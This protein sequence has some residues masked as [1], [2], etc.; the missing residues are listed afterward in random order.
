MKRGI[1]MN[2]SKSKERE[3]K[4]KSLL[5]F[6]DNYVV[7]DIET[8][9]LSPEYDSIIELCAQKYINRKLDSVYSSLINPGFSID[10]FITSLTGIT[11]EMLSDAPK[12]GE[13]II[14]F[15]NFIG[16]NILVGHNVN[17]DINFVYDSFEFYLHKPLKN[18]FVDTLRFARRLHKDWSHN[19]LQD[20]SKR[21]SFPYDGAH[22]ANFDC[23]L[24]NSILEKFRKEF[25]EQYGVDA[26]PSIA[27]S[28]YL[29]GKNLKASDIVT[30]KTE[31]DIDNPIYA[32]N[33]V[34]TGS[35]EKMTR[36]EAMQ[37]IADYGGINGD[38]V[39]KKTDYLI[40]GNNDYCSS[41]KNGKSAKHKKAEQLKL[42]GQNIEILPENVFYDMLDLSQFKSTGSSMAAVR[43]S[44]SPLMTID[45][46]EQIEIDIFQHI[47]K[48]LSTSGQDISLLR[49]YLDS[50]K[51]MHISN[52][53]G[54]IRFKMRGKKTYF[55]FPNSVDVSKYDLTAY[56]CENGRYLI[57]ENFDLSLLDSIILDIASQAY[58]SYKHYESN[59]AAATAKKNLKDYLKNNYTLH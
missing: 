27:L 52:Y 34:I 44:E 8:T 16:D 12:I 22:R 30:S 32:K 50:S 5:V 57:N 9:G 39:T 55:T 54:I 28:P 49:C 37:L 13:A 33:I 41:I 53:Y 46:F 43:S 58:K 21:Y 14:D 25:I 4:G 7:I 18:D 26:E 36:K 42:S 20:I 47:N 17:F 59:V 23:E 38:S 1:I 2:L 40:L 56:V 3:N 15:S 31:F 48:L 29:N 6:P 19:T 45:I 10:E 24:T 11:N 51:I 35:L